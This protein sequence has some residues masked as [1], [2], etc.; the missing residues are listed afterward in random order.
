M[1][2]DDDDDDDDDTMK[3]GTIGQKETGVNKCQNQ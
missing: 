1:K 3:R 2:E